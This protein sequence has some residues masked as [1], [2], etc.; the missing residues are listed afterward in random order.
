MV[1]V[2]N[3]LVEIKQEKM[4]YSSSGDPVPDKI[5]MADMSIILIVFDCVILI[6]S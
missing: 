1:T 4:Y 6:L 5:I 3:E 2:T